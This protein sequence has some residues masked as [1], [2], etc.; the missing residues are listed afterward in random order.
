MYIC[1]THVW[2]PY[3]PN[4]SFLLHFAQMDA[5]EQH[6]SRVIH[7]LNFISFLYRNKDLQNVQDVLN[8]P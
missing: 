7:D 2:D 3:S 5:K 8:Q 4:D 6:T 1:V